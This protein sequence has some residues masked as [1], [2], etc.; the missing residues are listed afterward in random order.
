MSYRELAEDL[1][2]YAVDMGYT[3]IEL[4]PIMEHPL[5]ASWGYQITGYYAPSSR[6]GTP[7]DFMYFVDMCHRAG[8]GLIL[9]W[10]PGHFCK[11]EH[12]LYRFDG[13]KL[14]EYYDENKSENYNWGTSYFDLG[15]NQVKSFLISCMM[16]WLEYYHVDGFRIDAVA[17]MLYLDYEKKDGAWSPNRYGGRE[18]LEAIDFLRQLNKVVF[19][20]YPHILIIAE[21]ST[22]W[23]MVTAPAYTGGLGFNYKWNMGW[24]NDMLEYMGYDGIHKKWHHNLITFS[25]MYAY[26][27]NFVLPLSH[28]E[29]V[30][31]KK[32]MIDKMWGD[33]WQKFASLR[34]FYAFMMAHPGKKLSFM[35]NEF[36][37]FREWDFAS[38]LEWFMLDFEMHQLM[39]SYVKDL[40]HFYKNERAFW[41]LDHDRD[42]FSWIDPNNYSQSI[43]SFLRKG[44]DGKDFIMVVC[45]FTPVAYEDYCIGVSDEASFVEV[46]NSD[47]SSYGG[48]NLVN[49]GDID[50]IRGEFHGRPY[51]IKLRVPPLGTVYLKASYGR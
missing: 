20:K 19:Q 39:H 26:S 21:E 12:G 8:L 33:Y 2:S 5:D 51:H 25:M 46:F 36:A 15:K 45:N 27:E 9:D 14:F 17:S 40:N 22:S 31:G 28:D 38:S 1:P 30:H 34:M 4:M 7:E 41:E 11:D 48:S 44:Q 24:M 6:Y 32:S 50:L 43:I 29:V 3:H 35:G 37:Q 16:Y 47:S 23:P 10:V 42:G 49:E 13:S 18:N